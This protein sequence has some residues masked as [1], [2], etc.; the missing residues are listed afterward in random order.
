MNNISELCEIVINL[1][2]LLSKAYKQLEN[3]WTD[4]SRPMDERVEAW[5]HDSTPNRWIQA[6]RDLPGLLREVHEGMHDIYLEWGERHTTINLTDELEGTI[7][8]IYVERFWE[9][10]S[11][12]PN[13][14]ID[15]QQELRNWLEIRWQRLKP[16]II[17]SYVRHDVARVYKLDW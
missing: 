4:K 6:G 12:F 10:K 11:Y 8:D 2:K 13:H 5:K 16:W 17:K 14:L 7:F 15:D 1:E 9:N 3:V